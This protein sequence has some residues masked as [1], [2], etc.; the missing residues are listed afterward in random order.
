MHPR[1]FGD[2]HEHSAGISMPADFSPESERDTPSARVEQAPVRVRFMNGYTAE[3][4]DPDLP[5]D[6]GGIAQVFFIGVR[7]EQGMELGPHLLK[8]ARHGTPVGTHLLRE[9]AVA[10]W[11]YERCMKLYGQPLVAPG[12]TYAQD[13][14]YQYGLFRLVPGLTLEQHIERG[15]RLPVF[16][17]IREL[18]RAAVAMESAEP[19]SSAFGSA[20]NGLGGIIHHD[21]KPPNVICGPECTVLIDLNMAHGIGE[22][23]PDTRHTRGTPLYLTPEEWKGNRQE[24]RSTQNQIARTAID[25]LTG[26][27]FSRI[28]ADKTKVVSR[29]TVRGE[30]IPRIVAL[31]KHKGVQPATRRLLL[32]AL[33]PNPNDRY[34]S[35]QAM[36]EA[37]ERYLGV[38]DRVS[39]RPLLQR[40][41]LLMPSSER[42]R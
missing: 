9:V 28:L 36:L 6:C 10:R 2:I 40:L 41:G 30:D 34:P 19:S 21:V 31:M 15:T 42:T 22:R 14:Q 17:I 23:N 24:P 33:E 29:R 16:R 25:M 32:R 4:L 8:R 3:I 12:I 1:N 13:D 11:A 26:G 7:D 27:A 39:P 18:L 5:D 35:S 38:G 37:V 20:I